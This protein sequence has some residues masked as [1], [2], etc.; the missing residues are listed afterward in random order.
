MI[1]H[2]FFSF[3]HRLFGSHHGDR[4]RAADGHDRIFCC[5]RPADNHATEVSDRVKTEK[6]CAD[7]KMRHRG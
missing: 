2:G 6:I 1:S 4:G 3:A 5:A 7:K